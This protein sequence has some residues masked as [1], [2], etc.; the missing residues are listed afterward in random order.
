MSSD[1][2][3]SPIGPVAATLA[4]VIHQDRILLIRRANR[5]DAGRWA[6]P[7]GKIRAGE[8]IMAAA[9]RELTEE[10]GVQGQA[11]Q[12][13]DALDV[14][15][16]EPSARPLAYSHFILIAVLFRWQQ[17]EPQAG[18]DALDARWFSNAE[19]DSLDVAHSFDV[20]R[21]ARRALALATTQDQAGQA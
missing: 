19:L 20:V 4:A 11:M 6:F 12:L 15:D 17:G 2:S 9:H 13:F 21:V 10:T 5:P 1:H 3:P 8:T 16:R 7:G 18:D 14:F